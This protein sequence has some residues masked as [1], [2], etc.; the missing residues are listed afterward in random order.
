MEGGGVARSRATAP[1]SACIP[2]QKAPSADTKGRVNLPLSML[3]SPRN[4][5]PSYAQRDGQQCGSRQCALA[6][7]RWRGCCS[8]KR[9]V[10][11]QGSEDEKGWK[12]RW[13]GRR[14]DGT[15]QSGGGTKVWLG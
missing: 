13:M 15:N 10:L 7:W 3:T 11:G 1:A 2:G 12:E 6:V 8:W 4:E 9:L 14:E 5:Y